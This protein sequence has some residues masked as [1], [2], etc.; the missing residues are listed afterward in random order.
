MKKTSK[1]RI[2]ILT[3]V[4]D[5]DEI[6]AKDKMSLSKCRE[7]LDKKVVKYTD[8]EI[9]LI[10][11]WFY[12]LA[13]ITYDEYFNQKR[14]IIIPLTANQNNDYEEGHYLRAS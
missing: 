11:D 6:A 13:A 12:N 2:I 7:I 3:R 10:R 14:T 8:V 9:L 4:N 5:G 1:N